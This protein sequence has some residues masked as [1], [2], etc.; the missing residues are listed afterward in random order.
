MQKLF[1]DYG[2]DHI[3]S[4]LYYPRANGQVDDTNK[5]LLRTLS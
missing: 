1:E 2:L 5:T 3:K 4:S